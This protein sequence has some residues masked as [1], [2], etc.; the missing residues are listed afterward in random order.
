MPLTT[1]LL[2][3][4]E[5]FHTATQPDIMWDWNPMPQSYN[6]IYP[7]S[8]IPQKPLPHTHNPHSSSTTSLPHPQHPSPHNTIICHTT[9]YN[10]SPTP[11]AQPVPVQ[12]VNKREAGGH[13]DLGG[14]LSPAPRPHP[15]GLP[16]CSFLLCCHHTARRYYVGWVAEKSRTHST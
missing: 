15:A 14:G 5:S 12:R 9:T 11:T 2:V 4:L 3:Q 13:I 1:P 7:P 6:H 8:L 10:L 16:R